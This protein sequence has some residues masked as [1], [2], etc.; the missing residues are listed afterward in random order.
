MSRENYNN[1]FKSRLLDLIKNSVSR[2]F[3]EKHLKD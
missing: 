3:K 1:F 2:L